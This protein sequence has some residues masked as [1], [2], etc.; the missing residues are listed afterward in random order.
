MREIEIIL[1][2]PRACERAKEEIL[3]SLSN[4]KALKERELPPHH[5]LSS[6]DLLRK[7]NEEE[8]SKYL[9][10]EEMEVIHTYRKLLHAFERGGVG[11]GVIRKVER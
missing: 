9:S 4:L 8:L 10:E 5:F 3:S 2:T 6:F 11:L 1:L 7:W